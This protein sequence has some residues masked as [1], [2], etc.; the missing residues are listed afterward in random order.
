[1]IWHRLYHKFPGKPRQTVKFQNCFSTLYGYIRWC[2]KIFP[3]SRYGLIPY[4]KSAAVNQAVS[5]CRAIGLDGSYSKCVRNFA[6]IQQAGQAG[7]GG[8]DAAASLLAALG[9]G[10][11]SDHSLDLKPLLRRRR[12]GERNHRQERFRPPGGGYPGIPL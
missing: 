11:F 6:S 8:A 5:T 3:A 7:S 10:F 4:R 9:S 12:E 1:M 2:E